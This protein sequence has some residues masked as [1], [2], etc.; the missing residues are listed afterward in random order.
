MGI[1]IS[2][3][4]TWMN[5]RPL[6]FFF[7]FFHIRSGELGSGVFFFLLSASTRDSTWLHGSFT[8]DPPFCF[9]LIFLI[10]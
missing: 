9:I 5:H 8:F 6:F 2:Q 7:F 4:G 3:S 1:A 10:F